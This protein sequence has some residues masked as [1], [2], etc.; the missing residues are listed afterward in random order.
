VGDAA[1]FPIPSANDAKAGSFGTKPATGC[2]QDGGSNRKREDTMRFRAILL[3]LLTLTLSRTALTRADVPRVFPADQKPADARLSPLRKLGDTYHPW[4]P[5]TTREDWE[6]EAQR[7]REQV[8]VATG[9]W[10]LPEKTELN[11]VV[12]GRMD[13]GDYTIEK[14]YFAS[15]PGHYV[16]GNLYRPKH[17]G[18]RVPG[19]LCPHG[20]WAN[21]R[22]HDAGEKGAAEQLKT[23]AE[24]YMS[25]ARSPLQARMVQLARM[26]CVVFFYDMVGYADNKPIDHRAGFNDVEAEL[27]LQNKMGLQTWNSI[28]A[29]DFLLSLPDVDPQRIGVTGASGGGT[30]TFMLCAVD[31]RPTVAFPAVMVSTNMQGGCVCE[32][33]SYLRIGV[34]NIALAALCAP[35]PQAMSGADDWTLDIE[36]K[37]LPELK[38]VYAL[39]GR[40]DL[41][42]AHTLSRFPHNYNQPSREMMFDWFNAHLGLGLP[43]PVKQTD[44]WPLTKEEL[45]VWDAEHPLPDDALSAEDVRAAMTRESRNFVERFTSGVT[46]LDDHRAVVEV[47]ARVML[48]GDLPRADQFVATE[49]GRQAMGSHRLISLYCGR[50][51]G[52]EQVPTLVLTPGG[53]FSGTAVLWLDGRGKACLFDDAGEVNPHVL[54]LLDA[55]SAV[56]SADLFLTGEYLAGDERGVRPVE[57][58]PGYTFGY[59]RPVLAERVRDILTLI[60]AARGRADVTSL[61]VVATG[62]AGVPAL[63]ARALA[64]KAVDRT[65][66]D[67]Q[68]FSFANVKD[69]SDPLLLPG[70]LKYG[71]IGGLAALA[72][73]APLSIHGCPDA[74]AASLA[75]LRAAYRS[76]EGKLTLDAKP[77]GGETVVTEMLR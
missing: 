22:F 17:A 67:L 59:N 3:T 62:D 28:R 18:G 15:R 68:G 64:G 77:L 30:Q 54:R 73:P 57:S 32:N 61:H 55:G 10:P 21:G 37:G 31:P 75:A 56:I 35:R 43:S 40:P 42:E 9:L 6:R 11:P 27:W 49:V 69:A 5:P 74:E 66:V 8:L 16:T 46:D 12:H 41:V 2:H 39:Y 4:T 60:A 45:S 47:A 38:Q 25:G 36:T 29:L 58:F 1:S 7:L 34:N 71:D 76:A 14:V 20:H 50:K 26:G 52:G 48:G 23:G 53:G 72:A 24:D 63:L 19:V 70:A 13:R 33:A 65:L 44:F 51:S